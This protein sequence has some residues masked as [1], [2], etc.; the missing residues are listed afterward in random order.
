MGQST[1]ELERSPELAG[2]GSAPHVDPMPRHAY[3]SD[4]SAWALEQALLLRE[5][6]FAALDLENIAEE[7]ESLSRSERD[8]IYSRMVVL[9]THLLKWAFQ[10]ELRS[11]SWR[12]SIVEA[13]RR[14]ARRIKMSPSLASYPA[15]VLAEA[16][17]DAREIAG[18]EAGRGM[19]ES[20]PWT[21]D[22][23]RMA[24]LD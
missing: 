10:P 13:R 21:A 20:C 14:I 18:A 1:L 4:L 22:E 11:G 5:K 3:D 15:E 23:A 24:A 9:L 12:A 6:R 19:P 7:I 17:A 8:E 16:Y 2:E